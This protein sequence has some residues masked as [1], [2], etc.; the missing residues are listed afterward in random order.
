[1]FEGSNLIEKYAFENN[2]EGDTLIA[3]QGGNHDDES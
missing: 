3:P 2:C 1:M